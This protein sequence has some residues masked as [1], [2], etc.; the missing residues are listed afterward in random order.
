MFVAVN[1]TKK[2]QMLVIFIS[3]EADE[4]NNVSMSSVAQVYPP[5][6]LQAVCGRRHVVGWPKQMTSGQKWSGR[7]GGLGTVDPFAVHQ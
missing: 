7:D 4:E 1:S 3:T 6:Q 5:C 2:D